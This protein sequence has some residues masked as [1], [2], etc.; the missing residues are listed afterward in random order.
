[1]S[2]TK[3]Q[4]SLLNQKP[5]FV[6]WSG[7]EEID[8]CVLVGDMDLLF[9][10]VLYLW[11]LAKAAKSRELSLNALVFPIFRLQDSRNLEISNQNFWKTREFMKSSR[12]F[13]TLVLAGGAQRNQRPVKVSL[14]IQLG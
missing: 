12:N 8:S 7:D 10:V 13:T 14:L 3:L 1:M 2:R 9:T 5:L 11:V 6:A 4:F